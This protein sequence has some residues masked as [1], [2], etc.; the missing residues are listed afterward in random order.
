MESEKRFACQ[1]KKHGA[2][3]KTI[4]IFYD[5]SVAKVF[6]NGNSK[7]KLTTARIKNTVTGAIEYE[8]DPPN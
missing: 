7:G 2:T 3:W 8:I 6:L 1:L 4:E 5:F